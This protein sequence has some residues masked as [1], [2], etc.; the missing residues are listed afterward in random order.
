MRRYDDFLAGAIEGD[1]SVDGTLTLRG[2]WK[3]N[4]HGEHSFVDFAPG[5]YRGFTVD[6]GTGPVPYQALDGVGD[7]FELSTGATTPTFKT[8]NA[9][10]KVSRG[11]GA[12][13]AEGGRGYE[14]RLTSGLSLRPTGSIR[15][16]GSTTWSRITRARNGSE[17]ART[18]IP[19]LKLEYQPHRSLFFR[20]V[21]EYV[22]G[23]SAALEDAR[24][25]APISINGTATAASASNRLR[26]DWLASFEPSPGTVAFFGYGS[27]TDDRGPF[28][29]RQLTRTSDGF[30][31]KLAY[32]IRR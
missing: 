5:A 31:V 18:I 21:G 9:S 11:R 10:A 8:L 1:E 13:F 28:A 2:G 20:V 7:G 23:R 14:T 4:G 19:R 29:F 25:G 17:F 27:S 32:Q 15:I 26:V 16:T 22:S 6:P 12:I 3:V 24:T 30:F